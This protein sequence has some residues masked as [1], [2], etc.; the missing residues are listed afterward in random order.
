M[1][2]KPKMQAV[3]ANSIA[4][5]LLYQQAKKAMPDNVDDGVLDKFVDEEINRFLASYGGNYSEA[6]KAIARMDMNW[7][8]FRDYQKRMM[9]VQ[10]YI[11]GKVKKD[12]PLK[13]SELLDYYNRV[14]D[15]RFTVAANMQ[16]RLIDI[17]FKKISQDV[18][19]LVKAE[20]KGSQIADEVFSKLVSGQD[21]AE[22]A[23]QYSNG[24]TAQ[25]GG[26]WEPVVMG[27]LASPYDIIEQKAAVMVPG[28][29]SEPIKTDGHIFIIYLISY[30]PK[31]VK[32]FEQV[33]G[34]LEQEMAFLQKKK[35]IDDLI[36]K[37]LENVDVA[38]VDNFV[39]YCLQ[40]IYNK[41]AAG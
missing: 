37:T 19:A 36:A 2:A 24:Y 1:I 6:E 31:T 12:R 17:D 7:K 26:L 25:Q 9:I 40:E 13:H 5:L 38:G 11:A 34:Q 30:S 3:V 21:F 28:T 15:E 41:A 20:D 16:F 23:K 29:F 27:N 22:L 8:S 14:K 33:Q 32:S 35:A 39:N 18:D 4:D 10:S